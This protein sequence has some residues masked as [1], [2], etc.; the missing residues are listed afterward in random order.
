MTLNPISRTTLHNMFIEG[1]GPCPQRKAQAGRCA[2]GLAG[3]PVTISESVT[4]CDHVGAFFSWIEKFPAI[5]L[6]KKLVGTKSASRCADAAGAFCYR[7]H[8]EV[9]ECKSCDGCGSSL[10][11]YARMVHV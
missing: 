11:E 10:W 7:C 1:R 5:E 6:F 4:S 8:R 9:D 2:E 3:E